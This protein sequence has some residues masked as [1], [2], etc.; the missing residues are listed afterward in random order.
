ME[1]NKRFVKGNPLYKQIPSLQLFIEANNFL[2]HLLT[3][4]YTILIDPL[5]D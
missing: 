2:S 3:L 1:V 5:I 4:K